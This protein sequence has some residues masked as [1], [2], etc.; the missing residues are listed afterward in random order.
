MPAIP[1]DVLSSPGRLG[2]L[3]REPL[4]PPVDA[5]VID[6]D[7]A[8][9]KELF[10]VP[11]GKTEAQ[12]RA[13]RQGDD[14]GREPGTRRRP[15][16]ALVGGDG[17]GE[18]CWSATTA[19]SGCSTPPNGATLYSYS[20]NGDETAAGTRASTYDLANRLIST[21]KAGVRDSYTYNGDGNRLTD[22]TTGQSPNNYAWDVNAS[23]PLLAT[24]TPGGSARRY[25]YG[26]DGPLSLKTSS[27]F[28]YLSDGVSS[29]ADLTDANGASKWDFTYEPFGA[30]RTC[31]GHGS[32]PPSNP[33]RFDGQYQDT[34]TTGSYN[35]RGRMY[36]PGTGTFLQDDAVSASPSYEFASGRPTIM[37][38]PLGTL[39]VW[40]WIGIASSLVVLVGL[41]TC[42]AFTVGVCG[43]I[44]LTAVLGAGAGAVANGALI[45][46]AVSSAAYMLSLAFNQPFSWRAFAAAA[47]G[48][49]IVGAAIGAAAA[50]ATVLEV[51]TAA[52]AGLVFMGGA[53]GGG[54][55][56]V[57]ADAICGRTPGAGDV[58]LG[59]SLGG[60]GGLVGFTGGTGEGS[61][62]A[63]AARQTGGVFV[64]TFGQV[65]TKC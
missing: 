27:N 13:D 6:L 64:N 14:L 59:A 18:L 25:I 52:S 43:G 62:I 8:F 20:A 4:D 30:C 17:V 48:G 9:G 11:V 40:G 65:E 28:Y 24:E 49:V 50:A 53:I 16:S 56:T 63:A 2:E 5:H 51:S 58:A 29:I 36:D 23:V 26:S 55:G 41:A 35:L 60:V 32:N 19:G 21:T 42:V 39:S 46:G 45:G 1:H 7:A 22:T 33:V 54:A 34:S 61:L 47:I 37:S 31:V 44:T 3:R 15:S 57:A 12:V 38:D 10:E